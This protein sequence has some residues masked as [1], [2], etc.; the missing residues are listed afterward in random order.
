MLFAP[1]FL[2]WREAVIRMVLGELKLDDIM[3]L[4]ACRSPDV[5]AIYQVHDFT[6]FD[7]ENINHVT[8][9]RLIPYLE[10]AFRI[11]DWYPGIFN[12]TM[13]TG[14]Q[15]IDSKLCGRRFEWD[16]AWRSR[17]LGEC[18]QIPA[19]LPYSSSPAPTDTVYPTG[20]L[21]SKILHGW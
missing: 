21:V 8:R 18:N 5:Y 16:M 11:Q 1:S 12:P 4:E 19:R 2:K 7:I 15:D 14:A 17:R 13:F 9:A 10:D 20:A 3:N 6:G